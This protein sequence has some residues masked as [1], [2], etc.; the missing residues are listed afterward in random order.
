GLGLINDD[1]LAGVQ[2]RQAEWERVVRSSDYLHGAF[3]ADAWG[4]AFVWKKDRSFDFPIKERMFRAIE[5]TAINAPPWMREEVKRL[6]EQY[7]FVHWHLAFPDVFR[8]P[9]PGE[10]AENEQAGWSGGFDVVLGNPPW[11]RIKLQ[12]QEWFAAY[13]RLDIAGARTAAIR[14]KMIEE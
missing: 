11:E 6:A 1:S 4:A 10:K 13:Q 5:R 7:Q 12:E 2:Q 9:G 14:G 8:V 3:L